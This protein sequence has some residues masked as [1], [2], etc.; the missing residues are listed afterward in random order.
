MSFAFL[1]A[2]LPS[3]YEFPAS[4][5][6]GQLFSFIPWPYIRCLAIWLS[7]VDKVM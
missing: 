2:L 5:P 3:I 4:G 6:T 1:T 7:N